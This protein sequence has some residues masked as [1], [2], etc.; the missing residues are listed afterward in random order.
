MNHDK[1]NN[2]CVKVNIFVKC[3]NDCHKKKEKEESCVEV[4]IHVDCNECKKH[5]DDDCIRKNPKFQI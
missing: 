1:R 4:N 3:N 5:A 2:K